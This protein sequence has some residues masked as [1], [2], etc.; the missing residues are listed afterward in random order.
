MNKIDFS[1][2]AN[3]YQE[4]VQNSLCL[5][6]KISPEGNI[7]YAN[8]IWLNALEYSSQEALNL[9]VRQIIRKDLIPI[10]EE[11]LKAAFSG[12][13]FQN[14]QLVFVSKSGKEIFVEGNGRGLF[15]DNKLMYIIGSFRDISEHRFM[16]NKLRDESILL[17]MSQAIA[18]IGTWKLDPF[19]EKISWSDEVYRIFDIKK[20]HFGGTYKEFRKYVHPKD[21]KDVDFAFNNAYQKQIPFDF[22]H[23]IIRPTG[24]IRYVREKSEKITGNRQKINLNY[25][26][27]IDITDFKL[28]E[29]ALSEQLA[30]SKTIF[31][32]SPDAMFLADLNGVFIDGNSIAEKIIGYKKQELIGKSFL[33]T[34]L[35]HSSQIIFINKLIE[36]LIK[37]KKSGPDEL[38]V[39]RKD[40]SEII[41]E[42]RAHIIKIN[43]QQYILGSFLDISGRK[44]MEKSRNELNQR[45]LKA[46]K[47][48]QLGFIEREIER[49]LMTLSEEA[50]KMY[51]IKQ[52]GPF[53]GTEFTRK[54]IHPDDYDKIRKKIWDAMNEKKIFQDEY[55]IVKPNGDIVWIHTQAELSED[56]SKLEGTVLNITR[57]KEIENKLKESNENL[58]KLS[59]HLQEEIEKERSAIALNLH[60]DLGQ[61]LTALNMMLATF[62]PNRETQQSVANSR[63]K[64]MKDLLSECMLSLSALSSNLRPSILDNLGLIEALKWF[65]EDISIKTDLKIK[66]DF[67]KIP[68]RFNS[69]CV[70]H[71]YRMVQES[72]TNVLRHAKATKV[73]FHFGLIKENLQISI[74]DNGCGIPAKKL[75]SPYSFGINGMRERAK[76]CGGF[77]DFYGKPK[78]GTLVLITLPYKKIEK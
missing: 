22:I 78:K 14:I 12:E 7:L 39:I 54:V 1:E 57:Y 6:H 63:I 11:N 32:S 13:T 33:K 48:A 51:G 27:V 45:L 15:K 66:S 38:I 4:L 52:K 43:G 73:N 3:L 37:N 41:V 31:E 35:L 75:N 29:Q 10:V 23:R 17:K 20:E 49:D 5:I 70:S 40:G 16:E 9:N 28:A 64:Q 55:R 2:H 69:E 18:H 74:Q 46:Q 71:I 65:L 77:I 30:Y 47:R 53:N 72:I 67:V 50:R 34:G 56:K 24:E 19:N 25:G 59:L 58:H 62:S 76:I 60:D 26:V 36:N 68:A 42:A 21:R 44:L 8:T 61:K